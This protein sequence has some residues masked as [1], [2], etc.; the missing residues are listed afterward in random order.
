MEKK[1]SKGQFVF[2]K[3][4]NNI[5]EPPARLIKKNREKAHII[6]IRNEKEG[7]STDPPDNKR[8]L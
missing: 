6:N 3:K 5:D 8:L 2:W 1:I 4:T 7:I